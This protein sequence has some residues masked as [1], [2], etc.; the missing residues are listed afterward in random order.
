[1]KYY[2]SFDSKYLDKPERNIG[3][4]NEEETISEGKLTG[5][6][7]Y[8]IDSLLLTTFDNDSLGTSKL[9]YINFFF[10]NIS[11]FWLQ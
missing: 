7:I 3:R 11:T 5:H 2:V 8:I 6:K 9:P 10:I 1:M 4:S